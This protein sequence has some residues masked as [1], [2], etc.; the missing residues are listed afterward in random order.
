MNAS[1]GT[2]ALAHCTVMLTETPAP[3]LHPPGAE[4]CPVHGVEGWTQDSP[5]YNAGPSCALC[6][7]EHLEA[8]FGPL[9]P[10]RRVDSLS[11]VFSADAALEQHRQVCTDPRCACGGPPAA[12]P[13]PEPECEPF[14]GFPP[15][16]ARYYRQA[17][18]EIRAEAARR[19]AV[20]AV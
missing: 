2:G 11:E 17:A 16:L 13:E 15:A 12:V 6:A 18:S 5:S 20:A 7:A 19:R 4:S 3:W 9:Q 14:A 8:K 10:R 1:D